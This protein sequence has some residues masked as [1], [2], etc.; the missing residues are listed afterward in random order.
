[1]RR[2][3]CSPSPRRRESAAGMSALPGSAI[4]IVSQIAAMVDAVPMT[5]QWPGLAMIAPC[6][7]AQSS[8]VIRPARSSCWYRRQ[9]VHVPSSSPRQLALSCGPPVTMIAGT[10]ALIRAHQHR[11]GRLVAARQQHHAVQRV[12][13]DR[14][15]HVHAHQ[16][17]VQHGSGA[18]V[19][20]AQ[21]HDRELQRDAAR[22]GHAAL[23]RFPDGAEMGVAVGQLAPRAANADDRAAVERVL[24]EA[25]GAEGGAPQP[26]V[27]LRRVEPLAGAERRTAHSC[28]PSGGSPAGGGAAAARICS[29]IQRFSA[30]MERGAT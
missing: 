13:P 25:L 27:E 20:L 22:L 21:G 7:A 19:V 1:M 3:A 29:S 23:H 17:A 16:V 11:G 5:P 12:R 14:L 24:A 2:P 28:G 6:R 18:H 8:S 9:S 15:L 10:S 26:A 30:S 4:P